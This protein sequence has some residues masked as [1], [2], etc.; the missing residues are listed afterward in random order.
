MLRKYYLLDT[1]SLY[2]VYMVS[3]NTNC[4]NKSYYLEYDSRLYY[5]D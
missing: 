4:Y 1:F 5:L 2:F 3:C